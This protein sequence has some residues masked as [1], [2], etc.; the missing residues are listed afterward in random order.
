M[1]SPLLSDVAMAVYCVVLLR[2]CC[3]SDGP[4]ATSGEGAA[5]RAATRCAVSAADFCLP[6]MILPPMGCVKPC[7][8]GALAHWDG[9]WLLLSFLS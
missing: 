4:T 2:H 1:A 3:F 9:K 5:G 8:W 7:S 6:G